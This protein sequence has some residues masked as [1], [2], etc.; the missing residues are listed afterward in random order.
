MGNA[1]M[2]R[3]KVWLIVNME[4]KRPSLMPIIFLLL[5]LSCWC[6]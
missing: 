4:K 5:Y 6:C 3:K 1:P 2:E